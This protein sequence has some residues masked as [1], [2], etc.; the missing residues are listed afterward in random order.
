MDR[1]NI[2][3][4][5]YNTIIV[6][7]GAAGYNA[8][9]ALWK[10]G[11]REIAMVTEGRLMGTS[12]NTGSDKQTYY[13]LT[14]CG[15]EPDSVGQMARDLFEGGCVDGDLA[16]AEAAGSLR[17][18]FHL[19]DI[20]V[21]FP[22]N[23]S[24]GYVGYKTDHDPLS[25]GT[26]VGPLTSRYM[27][28]CLERQV[29][30]R[31]VPVFDGYQAVRILTE[32][33]GGEKRACGILA[34]N[35][36]E[37]ADARKRYAVFSAENVIWATGGE[38]GMYQSSVYPFGQ[39]GGMGVALEAGA[40]AK[41]LTESQFGIASVKFRWNL[42][43]TFQQCIP[44]YVSLDEKGGDEREFLR[45]F[46]DT[47]RQLVTATFLKGYQWPFDPRKVSDF[48]SSLIDLL[49][50]QETVLRG[51]RVY[52]DF[53]RNPSALEA[54]GCFS[55]EH[56]AGEARAYLEN[57]G[58]L[59]NT[60]YLRLKHMNP[61]AIEVYG[62]HGIDISREYLEIAL[63]AQHN[64][65]GIA[66]GQWWE[67]SIRHLFA[68][69]E[70]NGSHGVYRPGGS[71]L[72]AGQVGGLRAAQ[73]IAANYP[74]LPP[75]REEFMQFHG[76]EVEEEIRFGE[77][78]LKPGTE[79]IDVGEELSRLRRRMTQYGASIRSAGGLKTAIQ[80]NRAQWEALAE[81][82]R[83]SAPG[84]LKDLY[85]LRQLLVSQFVYLQAMMDY[86][87]NVG[88]SRGSYLVYHPQGTLPNSRLGEE[89]RNITKE[90]D[91]ATLQ[92]ISYDK[93]SESCHIWW[94]PVRPIPE[95]NNWFENVWKNYRENA[96]IR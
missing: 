80:E 37:C 93:A 76:K 88:I 39:T 22:F 96:I 3:F 83:I 25:R 38:A 49:V 4:F 65:G 6:G 57:C 21:P 56:L 78:A 8:A 66:C 9:L 36:R 85:K 53:T 34:L 7:T 16:L 43:G 68:V 74:G 52:L 82:H 28:E 23:Q 71:A 5:K 58:A 69:G 95:E 59:Q 32:G 70:V 51:R 45:E 89:F 77:G 64:N 19:V 73:Y 10:L 31:G 17:A 33:E 44:R 86:D 90:T 60:P 15:Q 54:G 14:L 87:E 13:K 48:G 67:S 24:G 84:E 91:T 50:Y 35:K 81:C 46:F 62:S 79:K 30:E 11:Q 92:E 18:F 12:R 40:V 47:P 72:N 42:S 27:T 41:N 75:G 55:L 20:G 1:K 61:A 94:R 63:C 26:S 29:Q 2:P